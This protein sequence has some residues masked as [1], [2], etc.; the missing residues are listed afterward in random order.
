MTFLRPVR[1]ELTWQIAAP[2]SGEEGKYKNYNQISLPAAEKNWR[3]ML[4]GTFKW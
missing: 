3:Q 4:V 2:N 1:V